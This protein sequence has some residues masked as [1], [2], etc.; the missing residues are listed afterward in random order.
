LEA[1]YAAHAAAVH[2]YARRRVD[3]AAAEDVV[4]DT[5]LV[6][7]RRL[8]ALPV[9]DPLPWLLATARHVVANQRRGD[10]RRAALRARISAEQA[11]SLAPSAWPEHGVSDDGERLLR[12]LAS[13]RPAD[14]EALLL[15]AWEGLT[16]ARAAAALECSR[17]AFHVR[18][19]R[20]R[21]RLKAAIE[22]DV[23]TA[24][25]PSS[26]GRERGGASASAQAGSLATVDERQEEA[27]A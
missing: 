24:P 20:A 6:A 17:A 8:D 3:P 13:L 11:T 19:H 25:A 15:V 23:G 5:F 14:R 16:P 9:A 7:W 18:L 4:A 2:A 26:R 1:L 21:R 12:A 10:A 22:E 27:R